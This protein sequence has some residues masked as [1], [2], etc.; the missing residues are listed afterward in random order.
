M[1]E[2]APRSLR[3]P[4]IRQARRA[5]LEDPHIAPLT[6]FVHRIRDNTGHSVPYF[7][8]ADGGINA[9]ALLLLESPGP[10]SGGVEGT[11]LVSCD[12]P[13]FTAELLWHALQE[14]DGLRKCV[15]LWNIVPWYLDSDGPR[16]TFRSPN[17][18]DR[19][20]GASWLARL[21][22]LMPNLRTIIALGNQARD[23]LRL[24]PSECLRNYEVR[25]AMHPRARVST[26]QKRAAIREAFEWIGRVD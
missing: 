20:E 7:D 19:R 14:R 11:G 16:G 4:L 10:K 13:D 17:A 5:R 12:N 23:G 25:T 3:L 22:P 26:T 2:C 21:F 6:R 18:R 8:P 24:L 1:V 15:V 9:S